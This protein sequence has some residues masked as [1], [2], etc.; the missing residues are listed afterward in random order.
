MW[1]QSMIGS[2]TI[3]IP[4]LAATRPHFALK[5]CLY[6]FCESFLSVWLGLD[7]AQTL[8]GKPLY[9]R[10]CASIMMITEL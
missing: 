7:I 2:Y 9:E 8:L 1:P 4:T 5:P 10:T 6:I 3:L